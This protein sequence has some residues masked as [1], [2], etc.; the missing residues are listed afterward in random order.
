M[1]NL[2]VS[3][4][5]ITATRDVG[6]YLLLVEDSEVLNNMISS[7]GI[8]LYLADS[9]G[10]IVDENEVNNNGDGL[11]VDGDSHDD[12]FNLNEFLNNAN[13]GVTVALYYVEPSGLVFRFNQI[14]GNGTLGIDNTT[15]NVVD[16]YSN[17]WG[18]VTGPYHPTANPMGLGNDVSDNVLFDPWLKGI[19]Y[20]GDTSITLG[21]TA[22]L[23][24]RFVNS[25][26]TLPPFEGATVAFDMLGSY[27]AE[28]DSLGVATLDVPGLGIG[29]YS[30]SVAWGPLIDSDTL[31]VVWTDDSDG[32]G[33]LDTLDNCP[34]AYNSDQ[35]NTDA[36]PIDNGPVV[37]GNDVTV[38]N[39]DALGDVC[40]TDDDNDWLNDAEE[41][42]RGTNPL[43]AD[44]DGDRVVDGA[45][46]VL[47]SN[48]LNTASKPSCV[49]IVDGDRDCL[50]DGVEAIFGSDPTKKDTDGDGLTD[51]MEVKGW[52]TS[53][54]I[55]NTDGDRCDDD[56]EAVEINGDRY[57]NALDE[58]RV[59]QRAF[60]VQDDD[61]NDG[62]P[63][64][65]FNMQVSPAFDVN[66]DGV[67]NALDEALV[68]L[69]SSLVEP[70]EE[71]DCR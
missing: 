45:E 66:R 3:G 20:F 46:I 18:D 4:N 60:N 29:V 28:T 67:I 31:T 9:S 39:G 37:T 65:D 54:V 41:A 58:A 36:A 25:D 27:S 30:I 10:I 21:S 64:P 13:T 26:D 24:A 15:G 71:C 57:V 63:V 50:P 23:R 56:K 6:M 2:T 34:F 22:H 12:T 17:W 48:P 42:V 51:G 68:V 62:N 55:R 52:G 19:E 44:T 61:P 33:I 1:K 59:A 16:A 8:G 70:E 69:N 14:A 43:V 35:T 11:V 7:S 38:P 47:G 32:D 5:T 40:D 49:G 53:P